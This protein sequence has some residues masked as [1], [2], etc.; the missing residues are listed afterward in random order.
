MELLE[1]KRREVELGPRSWMLCLDAELFH[2]SCFSDP[3]RDRE[4]G[5]GAGVW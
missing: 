2:S 1:I 5:G 4:Q 3:A